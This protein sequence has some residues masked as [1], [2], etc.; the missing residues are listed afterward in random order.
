MLERL[1]QSRL[2]PV[3]VYVGV[4]ATVIVTG[5]DTGFVAKELTTYE[6]VAMFVLVVP[7]V[8]L[9]TVSLTALMCYFIF[10]PSITHDGHLFSRVHATQIIHPF[11][12]SLV[13]GVAALCIFTG[14]M[15]AWIVWGVTAGLYILQTVVIVRRVR[16]ENLVN[17]LDGPATSTFFL[18][19]HLILGT[20]IITVAAG[21][22]PLAP[23]KLTDLPEDTWV[24]DVRTKPEFHWNR[25]QAAENYPWGAGVID[26]AENKPKDRPV[27]V[28]CF[29]GHR[30][31]TVAVLL[32][33]LGF[34]TVYNLNWGIL[35]LVL[36]QR[37]RKSLGPFSLTRPHR[38][39]HRRG[40]DVRGISVGYIMCQ[41]LILVIAP[42]ENAIRQ[43]QVPQMLQIVG[44][45]LGILGLV[46]SFMSYRA[47]GRNF[48]VYAAP[49]RSGT[50]VTSGIYS[51]VRHPM[52]IGVILMFLGYL[53][54]F[55]SL[56]SVPLWLAF[57]VLY[58]VKSVKEEQI[59]ADRFPDYDEYRKRTWKFMPYVY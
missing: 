22:R 5:I 57:T 53:L 26:A 36:L 41:A 34:E 20:E 28:T 48:R 33:K 11:T 46:A 39:P 1:Y 21:A 51:K 59:L 31:P 2:L 56:V 54:F 58:I 49:R 45:F 3:L 8:F 16:L 10:I 14:S 30:S 52:Y 12:S 40:E 55:G 6:T 32:R 17:G 44:I 37:G 18:L 25:L 35:Y 29:S 43:V 47:L 27:L 7:T 38:D 4:L 24:V 15:A 42:L 19:L 9:F 13:M 50:L 23:W